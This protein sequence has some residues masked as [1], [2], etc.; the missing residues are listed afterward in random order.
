MVLCTNRRIETHTK[1]CAYCH[2]SG[3]LDYPEPVRYHTMRRA[4]LYKL[5]TL[6]IDRL[7]GAGHDARESHTWLASPWVGLGFSAWSVELQLHAQIS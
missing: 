5:D 3:H 6:T 2:Y 4:S 1:I 7:N